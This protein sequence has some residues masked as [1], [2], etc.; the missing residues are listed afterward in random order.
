MK[1]N[2]YTTARFGK[3][4]Y[5]LGFHDHEAH[6]YPLNHGYDEFFGFSAHGHDYFLLTKDIEDRTPDPKGHSA[7]VGPLM[8]NRGYKEFGEGYL[9][10][11]LHQRDN[12]L[13]QAP[14]RGPLL[15]DARLQNCYTS[16][17]TG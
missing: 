7:V 12:R 8:H 13:P 10:G 4:D 9:D 2:G 1:A 5:G 15:C 16:T 6:E 11:D 3:N 14:P 17:E